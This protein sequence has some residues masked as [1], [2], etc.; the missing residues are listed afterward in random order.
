MK[1][2]EKI[3][4]E[5]MVSLATWLATR[6]ILAQHG[7]RAKPTSN[8]DI[9]TPSPLTATTKLLQRTLNPIPNQNPIQ[10]GAP[11][12][13]AEAHLKFFQVD[14]E[15]GIATVHAHAS[16]G[17]HRSLSAYVW[18]LRVTDDQWQP[19]AGRVYEEQVFSMEANHQKEA[20][21]EDVVEIPAG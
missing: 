7:N 3:V 14:L 10:L 8:Q 20:S 16:L 9:T 21:F 13:V 5:T 18:R 1:P 15:A 6:A 4:V 19:L 12:V 11:G 2:T 17:D